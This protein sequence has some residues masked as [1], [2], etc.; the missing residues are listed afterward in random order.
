[1]KSKII[2]GVDAGGTFTDFV[3]IKYG[4]SVSLRA[5]KILSTPDAPERAILEGIKKLGLDSILKTRDLEIVHGSTVA[6]NAVLEN[7]LSKT[8]LV[9]NRGFKDLLTIGRQTRPA[10]YQLE[11]EPIEPPVLQKLCFETGGRLGADGSEIEGL[12]QAEVEDLVEEVMSQEPESVAINL[13]F[14]FVYIPKSTF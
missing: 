6:T 3:L 14:S 9:T 7:K 1:M 8:A 11:Y 4:E 5:L 13:L 10:L 12:S 2:L